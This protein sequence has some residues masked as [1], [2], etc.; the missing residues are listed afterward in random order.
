MSADI[1]PGDWVECVDAYGVNGIITG[2]TPG[3]LGVLRNGSLYLVTRAGVGR[4][5]RLPVVW[6]KG[7]TMESIDGGW[8]AARFRPIY[9]PKDSIAQRLTRDIPETIKNEPE[10]VA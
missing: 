4:Y 9:R 2:M 8:W 3:Q 1:G 6:L 5:T 10:P 7:V